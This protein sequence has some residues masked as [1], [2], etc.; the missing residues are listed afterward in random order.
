MDFTKID[1]DIFMKNPGAL[2]VY[3]KDYQSICPLLD[4]EVVLPFISFYGCI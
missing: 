4:L 2:K 3:K 1:R